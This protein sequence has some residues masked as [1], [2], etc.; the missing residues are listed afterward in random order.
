MCTL[1]QKSILYSIFWRF[2]AFIVHPMRARSPNR[3]YPVESTELQRSY[4][5]PMLYPH[6]RT[7]MPVSSSAKA[8][9]SFWLRRKL[10]W[11]LAPK[12]VD[13]L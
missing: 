9:H 5:E 8:H 11:P 7:E 2:H 6:P 1:L 4:S 3:V 13:P 12:S 10:K